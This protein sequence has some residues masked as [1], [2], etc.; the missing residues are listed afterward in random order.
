MIYHIRIPYIESGDRGSAESIP[1]L[2]QAGYRAVKRNENIGALYTSSVEY[3][4]LRKPRKR[5]LM[6]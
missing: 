2:W 6:N 1:V 5:V 4:S 3:S